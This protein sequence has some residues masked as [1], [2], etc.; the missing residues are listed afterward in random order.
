MKK[1][2]LRHSLVLVSLLAAAGAHAQCT[3]P[4]L[5]LSGNTFTVNAPGAAQ[6][7]WYL[8]GAL[9]STTMPTPGQHGATVAGGT[10][11]T[12]ASQFQGVEDVVLD[13]SNNIYAS[14]AGGKRVQKWAPNATAGV[15]I[16][17]GNG[18][19]TN[20]NQFW[21]N[22]GIWIDSQGTIYV[23]DNQ[24]NRVQKWTSGATTG[25]TVAGDPNGTSNTDAAHLWA[26]RSVWAANNGTVY[27]ADRFNNR[28]QKWMPGA[29]A[30][31][32]VAGGTG[33]AGASQLQ[34]PAGVFV[35]AA[36]NIYVSDLGNER[37]QKWAPGATAGVTAAGGSYGH[38]AAQL[39]DPM[40]IFVDGTG[41][42]YVADHNNGRVQ[43]W[44]P[45]ATAGITVA[46]VANG[47]GVGAGTD[48]MGYVNGI[49]V[50]CNGNVYVA[51]GSNYRVQRWAQNMTST[52]TAPANGAYKAIVTTFCGC[53]LTSNVMQ[54]G[55]TAVNN[56]AESGITIYP[57][58]VKD[59][60]TLSFPQS[61]A[62]IVVFRLYDPAGR[63]VQSVSLGSIASGT[64]QRTFA[65][66]NIPAG[67]Y[68]YSLQSGGQ[69]YR[70]KVVK[71]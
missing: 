4:V 69:V 39:N 64:A 28:V 48:S 42:V 21:T 67:V 6:I 62:G 25:V 60:I 5:T 59:E 61:Q 66:G 23:A 20:A 16:A 70:G 2:I 31:I 30:G 43:K 41:A 65:V 1:F 11:G 45:G 52:F 47:N 13:A 44:A 34:D 24:N 50:D 57:N 56:I 53:V 27:V 10:Y 18:V 38:S 46:G 71:E 36:G 54:Y 14:D 32:T 17:G 3:T 63:I 58:P 15:T 49:A 35:D 40:G 51:D 55:A 9:V 12:G 37:V 33:G 29:T 7:Q 68:F 8:N 22:E 19:G 26:P